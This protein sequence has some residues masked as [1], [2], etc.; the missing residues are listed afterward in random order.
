MTTLTYDAIQNKNY[1]ALLLMDLRKAFD[2]VS[3]EIL[4]PKLFHY[5]TRGPAHDLIKSYLSSRYQFVSINGSKSSTQPI[6][7]GVPTG[8]Y[9][10]AI[11]F[12]HLC[13]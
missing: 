1:S 10:R 9:P 2:T 12:S 5:G 11:T 8:L 7:I 13:Q 4:L 3:H 6:T